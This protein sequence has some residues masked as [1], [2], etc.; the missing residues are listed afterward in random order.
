M[1]KFKLVHDWNTLLKKMKIKITILKLCLMCIPLIVC[2]CSKND[3]APPL[4]KPPNGDS[5]TIDSIIPLSDI[6]EVKIILNGL[7]EDVNTYQSKCP[8][9]ELGY[10]NMVENDSYPLEIFKGR[11]INWSKFSFEGSVEVRVTV[12]DASKVPM[13]GDVKIWPSRYGVQATASG[14]TISFTITEPAQYSV[15]IGAEGY[16]QGLMIFADPPETYI[17][18]KTQETYAILSNASKNVIS[19][20]PYSKSGIIFENGVHDIGVYHV[21]ENIK[22]IYFEENAWVYGAF[23]MDGMPDVKIFGRGTLSSYRLDYRE[24][25]AVEAI[26][27]SNNITL[28]GI[29]IADFR[30]FAV[31]LIG[32]NNTVRWVKTIGGWVYNCDGIAAYKGSTVQNCFIWAND[33]A[34]KSYQDDLVWSDCV[35]WQL[36]NGGVIQMGWTNPN[37]TNVKIQRIDVLRTE[38]NKPG[39]NRGLLNY[40]GNHYQTPGASGYHCDWLIEDIVTET[41]VQVLF[42]IS[43]DP[44]AINQIHGLT[45]KNW[46]VKMTMN[47]NYENSIIGNYADI[48]FDGF[49]FDNFKFNDVELTGLNWRSELNINTKNLITP[50]F[51]QKN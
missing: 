43:P 23:I 39:F 34:I 19:N 32:Q 17:P 38:W 51:L 29:V 3:L 44:S 18:D 8:V 48:P 50:T 21:P 20:I 10:K 24:S 26:N 35:V 22:T 45:M 30:H 37:S 14:S 42:N 16:K 31:R 2:F 36:N 13:G 12:K 1:N 9:Y 47:T 41:P 4:P 28:E 5:L 7:E 27:Q 49:V 25:H 11:S 46:N 15:E 6:Y 40:V 33:D